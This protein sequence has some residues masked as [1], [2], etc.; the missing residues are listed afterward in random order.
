MV[1]TQR[2]VEMAKDLPTK[3]DFVMDVDG[4]KTTG[5][6]ELIPTNKGVPQITAD[7]GPVFHRPPDKEPKPREKD[8]EPR[9]P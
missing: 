6:I 5:T 7:P 9:K 3:F 8:D 1:D 2:R 4:V